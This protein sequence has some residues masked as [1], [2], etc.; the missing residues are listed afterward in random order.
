MRIRSIFVAAAVACCF[1]TS[2]LAANPLYDSWASHKPGTSVTTVSVTDM[3][4][5]KTEAEQVYTLKEVTPEKV[6]I[7]MKMSSTMMGT[8]TEM[9]PQTME[10]PATAAAATPPATP[11]TPATPTPGVETKTSEETVKIAGKEY[12]ATCT[13]TKSDANG[14][15]TEAKSW[16]SPEIPNMLLKMESN[17]EGQM[18]MNTKMEVTK[19]E[20]K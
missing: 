5:M 8:K 14:M 6:V 1:G 4:T 13:S 12:K 15:K 7:E 19:V 2:A 9:P 17:S 18:K 11:A 20:I 3:G 10:I 16:T